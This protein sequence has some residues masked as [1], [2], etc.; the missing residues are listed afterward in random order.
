M[1]SLVRPEDEDENMRVTESDVLAPVWLACP[2]CYGPVSFSRTLASCA[3]CGFERP[4]T[5]PEYFDLRPTREEPPADWLAR[6]TE[7][8]RWY[9]EL[10][11][12]PAETASCFSGDY[13][14]LAPLLSP[15]RGRVVDIGGGLGLARQFV[16]PDSEYVVIEPTDFWQ[17]VGWAGLDRTFPVLRDTV[18]LVLGVGEQ[19]PLASQSCD[20]ALSLWSLNH[21]AEPAPVVRQVHRVLKPGGRFVIVLEDVM[22]TARDLET[23]P[24]LA[25]QPDL[26]IVGADH[27]E[28]TEEDFLAHCSSGFAVDGRR[29][30]RHYL[31]FE[32]LRAA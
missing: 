28:I 2:E 22:P 20:G 6:Q 9:R 29:W 10:A 5:S 19:L 16:D 24:Y 21:V 12:D 14:V 18:T 27:I 3:Q 7:M 1:C 15:V 8:E 25:Q 32:L 13:T 30:V 17:T 11:T 31:A 4:Q 26:G 23:H